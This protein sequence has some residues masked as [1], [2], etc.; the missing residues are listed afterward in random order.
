[1]FK[2][3]VGA[4]GKAALGAA[5]GMGLAGLLGTGLGA[6][7]GMGTG[8][9]ASTGAAIGG[10]AAALDRIPGGK[11]VRNTLSHIASQAFGNMMAVGQNSGR[12]V[13]TLSFLQSIP[14]FGRGFEGLG[15]LDQYAGYASSV[16]LPNMIAGHLQGTPGRTPAKQGNFKEAMDILGLDP[17]SAAQFS[18]GVLQV[19]GGGGM[20]TNEN[21]E[22]VRA[23]LGLLA[24]AEGQGY[25]GGAVAGLIGGARMAG[26]S[27]GG[28]V[29]F[30]FA[31]RQGARGAV[32]TGMAG[33]LQGLT[34]QELASGMRDSRGRISADVEGFANFQ[35][36]GAGF[37]IGA[38]QRT[39]GVNRAAAGMS[40]SV[41]G[42]M[43]Q[44]LLFAAAMDKAGGD[45]FEATR[46]LEQQRPTEMLAMLRGTGASEQAIKMSL[47]AGGM[48]TSDVQALMGG[49][50]A[51]SIASGGI[52]APSTEASL[53]VTPIQAYAQQTR[54]DRLYG[55]VNVD[56]GKGGKRRASMLS[57]YS[58]KADTDLRI[59]QYQL[60][61]TALVSHQIDKFV[62][63]VI[64]INKAF[65]QLLIGIRDIALDFVTNK[66]GTP[67]TLPSSYNT[68]AVWSPFPGVNIPGVDMDYITKMGPLLTY[69]GLTGFVGIR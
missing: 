39:V 60:D 41:Y 30:N 51:E 13:D 45:Q 8:M 67:G 19:A 18:A 53:K 37:G 40:A 59:E 42:N 27:Q 68:K 24:R 34:N 69:V 17:A 55:D 26:L 64:A 43:A 6:L 11:F 15:V 54:L 58:K 21:K 33:M 47:L 7:A 4:V 12:A 35:N 44:S 5:I 49:K 63:N 25:G 23:M 9:G 52:A 2:R 48:T 1:M 57:L 20:Y 14:G 31:T 22:E 50:F 66:I 3:G 61:R 46:I 32:A 16:E 62:D 56:D 10:T 38:Y 28:L 65:D 36:R 29:E